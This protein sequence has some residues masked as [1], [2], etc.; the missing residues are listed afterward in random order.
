MSATRE[1][2][3][4]QLVYKIAQHSDFDA[5]HRLNY[6]TFVEEI[7]QHAPNPERRLIDRFHAENTYVICLSDGHLIGMVCGRSQRPF[8]LDQKLVD[9]DSWLPSCRKVV[10]I[11]L[12]SVAHA[13]RK[14]SV[15]R[16]LMTFLSGHFMAQGCDLAVIS[17]TVR[18][19]K[20]YRHLGFAPFGE[21]VGSEKASY[22]PMYLTLDAFT[23]RAAFR[24]S[25]A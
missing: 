5:I 13:H 22:Q 1:D 6:E 19:L 9:L 18:E 12:L 25:A 14:T 3:V 8:S 7:P 10:E 16:G 20:L 17:G 2:L 11:R 21:R 23:R 15:F 24:Q 4:G